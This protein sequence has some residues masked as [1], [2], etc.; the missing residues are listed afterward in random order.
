MSREPVPSAQAIA[1]YALAFDN[2]TPSRLPIFSLGHT[3]NRTEI[4]LVWDQVK[5]NFLLSKN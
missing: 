2:Y 4:L 5:Y 3:W 1:T